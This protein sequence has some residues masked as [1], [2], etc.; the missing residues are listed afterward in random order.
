M[1]AVQSPVSPDAPIDQI[2]AHALSKLTKLATEIGVSIVDVAGFIDMIDA[3]SRAQLDL[4][5]TAQT[6]ANSVISSNKSMCSSIEEVST[7]SRHALDGVEQS[8]DE[9]RLAGQQTQKVA[10]WVGELEARMEQVSSKLD[11]V[12]KSN[13][14][15]T[16]IAKQV[17]ILAVNAKIEAARAGDMG[18]G[19]AVV[20][21]AINELSRKTADAA[22]SISNNIVELAGLV[23]DL[24]SESEEV[25]SEARNVIENAHS[26]DAS[27]TT[28]AQTIR[29]NSESA[30][31]VFAEAKIV[32]EAIQGFKPAFDQIGGSVRETARGIDSVRQQLNAMINTSEG[33]VQ[34]SVKL[35]GVT[36][37]HA[38]ITYVKEQSAKIGQ[39][40]ED[41]IA[42]N[43]ITTEALFSADYRPIP[44]SDPEQ[45]MAPFTNFTDKVLPQIQEAAL[46]FDP[47][48][49]FCAA[50]DTNGY[51]PTHN[52]KFSEPQGADP[53]WNAS[54]SRNR[55]VFNDRVGLKAGGSTEPFLLQVYRRDLGGGEFASMKDLS[56]PIFVDGRHWGGLRLA[57][58]I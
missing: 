41:G 56:A 8:V 2:D 12:T 11:T 50:V 7:S 58:K 47:K 25:S 10:S 35:G 34:N 57:Y 45:L 40:F 4:V 23:K 36:T 13:S 3:K 55:R 21:E 27:L 31:S 14:E 24:R 28:I 1:Q 52:V 15:I 6:S 39:L 32:D 26:T 19:F 9:M 38:F 43:E 5:G 29:L 53:V 18:R 51:L 46:V 30:A 48:V 44:G 17:N 49:V 20:A 42:Q 22:D 33:I 54:H 37:E 16:A